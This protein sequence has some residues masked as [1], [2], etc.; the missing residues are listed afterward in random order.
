MFKGDL[1]RPDTALRTYVIFFRNCFFILLLFAFFILGYHLMIVYM[2]GGKLQNFRPVTFVI[3]ETDYFLEIKTAVEKGLFNRHSGYYGFYHDR[4]FVSSILNY[5]PHGWFVL[6][7]YYLVGL[8]FG[9]NPFSPIIANTVILLLSSFLM[10]FITKNIRKTLACT[11]F[12]LSFTP[13]LLFFGTMMVE[14]VFYAL[15]LILAALLF[16]YIREPSRKREIVYISVVII[17]C[18]FRI[19]NLVFFVP[20]IIIKTKSKLSFLIYT[21]SSAAASFVIFI[22]S[23]MFSATYPGGFLFPLKNMI[24]N[25]QIRQSIKFFIRHFKSSV[26]TF[27]NPG[28]KSA[29]RTAVFLRYFMIA[30][31][32]I[33]LIEIFFVFDFEKFRYKKRE[34][35]NRVALSLAL[36]LILIVLLNCLFYEFYAWRDFRVFAPIVIFSCTMIFLEFRKFFVPAVIS[37]TISFMFVLNL[38]S[39]SILEPNFAETPSSSNS[40]MKRLVF[41]PN[42]SRWDNT[43]ITDTADIDIPSGIGFLYIVKD[44]PENPRFENKYFLI[45]NPRNFEGYHL[46]AQSESLYLYER[47]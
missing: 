14:M 27:F 46:V 41:D 31:I 2:F 34:K 30:L 17:A 37:I 24:V 13:L 42:G 23:S 32:I 5:G 12:T 18:M 19:T 11:V 20:L 36:V 15:S 45:R 21:I 7:P 43:V 9:W 44:F 16:N 6:V 29:S 35:A 3:D 4:P 47:E 26:L 8:V 25:R 10:F 33:F 22:V 28:M 38:N 1:K 40:I 39:A